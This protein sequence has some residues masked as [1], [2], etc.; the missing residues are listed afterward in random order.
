MQIFNL[1]TTIQC[2]YSNRFFILG[3]IGNKVYYNLHRRTLWQTR[4]PHNL[5]QLIKKIT[6]DFELY[7]LTRMS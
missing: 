1:Y 4:T 7:C 6:S 3:S 2:L 5:C